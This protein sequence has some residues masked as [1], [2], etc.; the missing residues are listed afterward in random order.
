MA[1]APDG[2][3]LAAAS[4]MSLHIWDLAR[5]QENLAKPGIHNSEVICTSFSPDGRTIASAGGDH[6]IALW[7][8]ASGKQ[9]S[10]LRGHEGAISA[11]AF[12]PNGRL[13]ASASHNNEQAVRLWDVDTGKELHR[14]EVPHVPL[15]NGMSIGV[16]TWVA[17][18]D[19]GKT[20]AAGGTDGKIRLWDTSNGK[21]LHNENIKGLPIPPKTTPK[22]GELPPLPLE[23]ITA[24]AFNADGRVLALLS[25]KAIHVADTASGQQLFQYERANNGWMIALSPDGKTLA[26][27]AEGL[28]L[29]EAA[30]GKELCRMKLSGQIQTAAFSPDGRT[31]AV[32]DAS[33][34]GAIRLF[35]APSGKQVLALRGHDSLVRG[36]AFSPDGK[37]L[38][39]GQSDSTALVWDVSAARR[40]LPRKSLSAKDLERLWTDLRDPDAAKAHAAIWTL[41]A[42]PDK[43][44]PFLQDHLHPVPRV[45]TERLHRLIG[46][47]D[48]DEFLRREEASSE[49]I[50]LGVEAESALRKTLNGK[51]SLETRRRLETLIN[52]IWCQAEL[53]P[54]SLRQLRA[55]QVLEQIGSSQA[56]QIL[57]SLARGA[58]AAPATRDA[59]A[60]VARLELRER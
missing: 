31:L 47:L 18:A 46:D 25:L 28:S 29:M 5:G 41:V 40:S 39:S 17:F 16:T 42:E 53:T 58:P 10:S 14:H 20:L 60:A 59:T 6:T 36:L 54:E 9:R 13:L 2:K 1:F 34:R 51:P 3:K 30:S 21:E 50:K 52:N 12:S 45:S 7:D 32:G 56:R 35:D 27:V 8:A 49:L 15:A 44:I 33:P 23:R 24:T 4:G 38:V 43:A 26:Y 57:S 11:M 37:K 48:S 22:P 19:K 55:I